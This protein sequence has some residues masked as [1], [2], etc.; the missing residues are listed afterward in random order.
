VASLAPGGQPLTRLELL[1]RDA[2]GAWRTLD[3]TISDLR[4][5]H[6]V[7][8]IVLNAHDISERKELELDLAHQALYDDL[9]GL[10]NRALFR[11]RVTA[12]LSQRY[13]SEPRLPGAPG[14]GPE[15]AVMLLDLDEFKTVNDSLGHTAGDELLAAVARR[16]A[17]AVRERDTIARLGGD[18]FA[19]LVQGEARQRV[20]S[21][22]A[23]VHE[24]LAAPFSVSGRELVI[25]GSI[26]VAYANDDSI[27]MVDL[28]RNADTAMY[29]AKRRGKG[30]VEVFD[31][32]MHAQV[33]ERLELQ[34]DLVHVLTRDEL[35]LYY[36]P[37]IDL[38][39]GRVKGFE[40][41]SRWNHPVRGLVSPA[42][43]V[44]LAEESGMIVPI[45]SWVL[46]TSL[47]QLA[48][49][50][51][52][53]RDDRLTMS[54][55]LSARQLDDDHDVHHT[56][57]AILQRYGLPADALEMELT[58]SLNVD[59]DS[60]EIQRRLA[61]I[62]ALGVGL[63]ADDFGTGFASYAAVQKLPYSCIKID[64][65]LIAGLA[66]V[67]DERARVQIRSIIEMAHAAGMRVVAE[68]IEGAEQ[69][70]A[71][72]RLHCDVG[73]GYYFCRPAPAQEAERM[74][75]EDH[76]DLLRRTMAQHRP[77]ERR[78]AT[79]APPALVARVR[80]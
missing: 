73:Q 66:D 70:A 67:T 76:G 45:T 20:L 12:A 72:K 78:A 6:A 75:A 14:S 22:V 64:R 33:T 35:L 18:E 5:H 38:R 32:S 27:D 36:Q 80:Q 21:V 44:P 41:L 59:V 51:R 52:L 16:L 54:V 11:Q 3:V 58:E 15:V 50:R 77:Q 63:A 30:R 2:A 61:A 7:Q 23:R 4:A 8:G 9:T 55:N 43:F 29:A 56:I 37:L 46:E 17:G 34:N 71:L 42:S 40:A 57:H 47:R 28:L 74:L 68:G 10:A 19:V 65:K 53:L 60:P 48:A 69:L 1:V 31:D 39:T 62:T 13:S 49:W 26:G 24:A 25:D 79:P